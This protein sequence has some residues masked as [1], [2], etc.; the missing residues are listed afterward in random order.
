VGGRKRPAW[1]LPSQH[2]QRGQYH[3][4][5]SPRD[6]LCSCTDVGKH[7][8]W[9][10]GPENGRA[11]PAPSTGAADTGHSCSDCTAREAGH[12]PKTLSHGRRSP[13]QDFPWLRAF[14]GRNASPLGEQ[15][16]GTHLETNRGAAG[17]L[18]SPDRRGL[19][20]FLCMPEILL[21][22]HKLS[23]KH[24]SGKSW[25]GFA[26]Q[27]FTEA[28]APPGRPC[29]HQ[30]RHPHLGPGHRQPPTHQISPG[31]GPGSPCRSPL[32]LQPP[33][34]EGRMSFQNTNSCL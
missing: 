9:R 29:V 27:Q 16:S 24:I 6:A 33:S 10:S 20:V 34:T 5:P 8:T 1:L 17:R 2:T 13:S 7:L 30:P 4:P 26:A 22:S 12:G 28:R 32:Q 3:I 15:R 11:R 14:R 25:K 21:E 19:R 23:T 18:G 31:H